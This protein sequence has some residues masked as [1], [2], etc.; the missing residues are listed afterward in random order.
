MDDISVLSNFR[1]YMEKVDIPQDNL[2]LGFC[3]FYVPFVYN[4]ALLM[5]FHSEQ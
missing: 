4:R 1:N 5:L 2:S 3:F